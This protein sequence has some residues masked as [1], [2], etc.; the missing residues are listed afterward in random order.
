METQEAVPVHV[1]GVR[2]ETFLVEWKLNP[3]FSEG[4]KHLILE[5]FLVEWKHF[6]SPAQAPWGLALKPS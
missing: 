5:T 2:L 4:D 3:P 6:S 1:R